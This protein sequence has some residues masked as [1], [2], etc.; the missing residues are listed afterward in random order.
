MDKKFNIKI[1]KYL[2][3]YN[4]NILNIIKE[5]LL[6][7]YLKKYIFSSYLIKSF[8]FSLTFPPR[9]NSQLTFI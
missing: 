3:I 6:K 2:I 7:L 5:K 9:S 1:K 8:N 4:K